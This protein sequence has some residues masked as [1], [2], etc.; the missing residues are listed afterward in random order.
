VRHPGSLQLQAAR[1]LPVVRH[2]AHGR[3][4]GLSGGAHPAVRAGALVGAVVPDP[5]KEPVR[6]LPGTAY[7]GAAHPAPRDPHVPD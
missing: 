7:A 2:A 1:H 4:G 6:G 5:V 3:D